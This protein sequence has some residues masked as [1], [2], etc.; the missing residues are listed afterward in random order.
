MATKRRLSIQAQLFE[1]NSRRQEKVAN[2]HFSLV[3]SVRHTC[4]PVQATQYL[5]SVPTRAAWQVKPLDDLHVHVYTLIT[6]SPASIEPHDRHPDAAHIILE[7][8]I[9]HFSTHGPS[10]QTH[11]QGMPCTASFA[12][13]TA[14]FVKK[15]IVR[16]V[17]VSIYESIQLD[18]EGRSACSCSCYAVN[19]ADSRS[20][21][22]IVLV[23][24]LAR[25]QDREHNLD[26]LH[27]LIISRQ[28]R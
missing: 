1:T 8:H 13:C 21:S 28:G 24:V 4:R 9:D 11:W 14:F 3:I 17:S 18:S 5:A 10:N 22:C 16:S 12:R 6:L 25:A 19:L 2:G 23:F 27:T 15:S 7:P 20:P 26:H